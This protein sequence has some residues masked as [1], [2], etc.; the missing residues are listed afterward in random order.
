MVLA[1]LLATSLAAAGPTAAKPANPRVVLDTTE[2]KI[3]L[4]LFPDKAPA[5][6]ENFLLY[7][8]AGH[9]TGTIFHR[10]IAN[11]MI[12]GGF[13][14][15]QWEK[16]RTADPIPNESKNGLHNE[17]GTV[18]M[19]R[20]ADKPDSATSQ[21]FINL[22]H[23]DRLNYPNSQGSGYAVF[24]KVVEGMNVADAIGKSPTGPGGFFPSDVP[25]KAVVIKTATVL[26]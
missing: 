21:F 7:V 3:V 5:T 9:Y 10:V 23:N 25:K 15:T 17:R 2:G 8:K 4:E 26:K 14:T 1:L 12:Q 13:F 6:V 18:S 16:K 20:V 19:A 22:G 24:G 11:F